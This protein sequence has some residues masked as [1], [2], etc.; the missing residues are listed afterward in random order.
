GRQPAALALLALHRLVDLFG[1]AEAPRHAQREQLAGGVER[2][3]VELAQELRGGARLAIGEQEPGNAGARVGGTRV[4][5][6]RGAVLL[7]RALEVAHVL[8][9]ARRV[10]ARP[11]IVGPE[12]EARA[13]L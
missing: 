7:D 13:E 11:G 9:R 1:L 2:L 5:P 8:R 10:V 12:L 6:D 4:D 3:A